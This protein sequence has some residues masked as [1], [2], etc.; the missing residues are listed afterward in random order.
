[1]SG[2]PTTVTVRCTSAAATRDLASA[3]AARLRAGDLLVL[4]GGLGA[5][6]TTFTQG[7]AA[8]LGVAEAVTSPTFVLARVHRSTTGR[9]TLVHVDAYRLSGAEE[10]DDLDL[11]T[12]LDRC[13]TVVEWGAGLA[14]VLS[15]DRLEVTLELDAPTVAGPSGTTGDLGGDEVRTLTLRG[16]G[17][18]WADGLDLGQP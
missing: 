7:L 11:D 1:M 18:R 17:G 6:K 13:I 10:L 12:D 4:T 8:G 2:A 15:R 3:L 16:V 5:G 14:E 9:P